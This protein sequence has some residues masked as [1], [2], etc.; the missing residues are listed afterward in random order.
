M[1]QTYFMRKVHIPDDADQCWIWLGARKGG[2]YGNFWNGQRPV[3]A[4]R[5]AYELFVGEIPEGYEVDHLCRV[6]LCVNPKHLE[7]VTHQ[8]NIR[9]AL[10][11]KVSPTH[12]PQGHA[13]TAKNTKYEPGKTTRKRRCRICARA[14]GQR[15]YRK[16]KESVG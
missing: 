7:A 1:R 8:E 10:V 11:H 12:C 13:F 6:R 15:A 3:G 2:G 16:R 4:H 14:A 5:Y 9:R